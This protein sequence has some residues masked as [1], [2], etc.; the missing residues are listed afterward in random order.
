MPH[1][2]L[3]INLCSKPQPQPNSLGWP[4]NPYLYLYP[5]LGHVTPILC[6]CY[7]ET[8]E[9]GVNVLTA[10]QRVLLYGMGAGTLMGVAWNLP[11]KYQEPET[12]HSTTSPSFRKG[13]DP[14]VLR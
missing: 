14:R 12:V 2:Y 11:I 8:Q 7:L 4:T 3:C 13:K 9:M 5:C 1:K 6:S 10:Q